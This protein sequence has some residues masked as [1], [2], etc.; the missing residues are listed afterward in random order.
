VAYERTVRTVRSFLDEIRRRPLDP[1]A[2]TLSASE[3]RHR[4]TVVYD[5]HEGGPFPRR[6]GRREDQLELVLH[7]HPDLKLWRD[8]NGVAMNPR[9][10]ADVLAER[11]HTI[12]TPDPTP[13]Y[14]ELLE[15]QVT[16]GTP[17]VR[18]QL[19][20][21]TPVFE[22]MGV[23][24]QFTAWLSAVTTGDQVAMC[25]KVCPAAHIVAR[26][27]R[28]VLADIAAGLPQRVVAADATTEKSVPVFSILEV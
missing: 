9:Q 4:V 14:L 7:E 24:Y 25:V 17:E 11:V 13:R 21:T 3:S 15:Q 19:T 5:D 26:A 18:E 12:I 16:A 1:V 23:A 28:E 8:I 27:W 20:F 22:S 10:F 6:A 2:S